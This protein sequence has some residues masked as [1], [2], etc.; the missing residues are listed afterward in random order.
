MIAHGHFFSREIFG[1]VYKTAEHPPLY[2]PFVTA[3]G[4]VMSEPLFLVTVIAAQS[5]Q[6][7]R[8]LLAAT[9]A[10]A[11]VLAPW[12]IRNAAVFHSATLAADSN[13]VIAGANCQDTQERSTPSN[14]CGKGIESSPGN[15]SMSRDSFSTTPSCC[16]AGL[17]S[18]GC[19][20]V[21]DGS[22]LRRS[23]WS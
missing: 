15:G 11:L 3:H 12:V 8:R 4:L 22:C 16:R 18:S 10:T 7:A 5:A 6:R 14:R 17:G 23:R 9:A 13:A 20:R 21:S 2:P 1:R 19:R